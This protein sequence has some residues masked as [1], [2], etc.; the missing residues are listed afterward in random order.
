MYEDFAI[1]MPSEAGEGEV[2][3]EKD[4]KYYI[5]NMNRTFPSFDLR[6]GKIR[7]NH[8]IIYNDKKYPLSNFITP[9]TWVRIHVKR[10]NWIQSMKGVDILES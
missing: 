5:R 4:G 9:G 3:E 2:F 1:G 8:T 6:I 7:A 10:I